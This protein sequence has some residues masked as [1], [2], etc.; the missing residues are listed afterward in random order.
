MRKFLIVTLLV[1]SQ[2]TAHKV[3]LFDGRV[4]KTHKLELKNGF[5]I[6]DDTVVS[7]LD[8]K[9][10]IFSGGPS[11]YLPVRYK[12]ENV[13]SVLAKAKRAR[14]LYPDASGIVLLDQGFYVLEMDSTRY[15]RYHFQGLILKDE[16]RSWANVRIYVDEDMMKARV[17]AARCIKPDGRVIYLNPKDVKITKPKS[18]LV[19]F[20]KGK[21]MSFTIPGVEVG[22]IVEYVYEYNIFNPW[23]KHVFS[24]RWFFGGDKPVYHSEVTFKLPKTEFFKYLIRNT[25][26]KNVKYEKSSVGPF[27]LYK[28]SMDQVDPYLTEPQMPPVS[29]VIPEI[30]ITNQKSWDYLYTWY[31]KFQ[32]KRMVITPEIQSLADSIVKGATSLDDSIAR[33]YYWVQQ[34]I[35][36]ISIKGGASSGVSGH[37]ATETLHKGY[38]DCTDKS[39]LFSTL[40]RAIG[41]MGYPVYIETNDEGT[42][43]KD[44]P[45]FQG[46][47]A[48]TEIITRDGRDFFLDATGSTSRYPYFWSADHGVWALNAQLRKISFIK[49]PP[50]E[51]NWRQYTY[52]LT[53]KPDGTTRVE[54]TGRY[55]GDIEAGIRWYWQHV[56]ESERK[57]R[58]EQMIQATAPGARLVSYELGPLYDL[59]KQFY[60]KITFDIPGYLKSIGDLR[61]L[62]LPDVKNRYRFPEISVKNRH[63]DI[64][65]R[66]SYKVSHDF[67]VKFQGMKLNYL[68]DSISIKDRHFTYVSYFKKTKGNEFEYHDVFRRWDRIIPVSDYQS[69]REHLLE[70]LHHLRKPV[71]FEGGK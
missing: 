58:M 21:V 51:D 18:G 34:N 33:I 63:Y 43:L 52:K 40:L 57:N 54:F 45:S 6:L 42:F 23:D 10:V 38:G 1:F 29:D 20:G 35:R 16:A 36:Y 49:V 4:I 68:P 67:Y 2:L 48:I 28:F 59:S 22:D 7:K 19:F 46:N 14:E 44:I 55:T 32:K 60:L 8:V 56:K 37:P 62:E 30:A 64:V 3:E 13:D 39:I 61:L 53:I 9:K 11:A 31:A 27:N 15:N 47:H 25:D 24:E 65:Y 41:V 71:I 12:L 50:P 17:L 70:L 5:Y 66:T 26:P 69:Y